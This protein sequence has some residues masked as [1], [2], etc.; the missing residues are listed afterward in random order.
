M[1]RTKTFAFW[2]SG[3]LFE[4]HLTDDEVYDIVTRVWGTPPDKEWFR[5]ELKYVREH[6]DKFT[7]NIM[8]THYVGGFY[9]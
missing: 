4:R 1:A 3:L 8:D 6:P 7:P 5:E 9:E 2:L